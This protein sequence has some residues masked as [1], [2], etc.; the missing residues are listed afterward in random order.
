VFRQAFRRCPNPLEPVALQ[1]NG[2]IPVESEPF[3][4][5]LAELKETLRDALSVQ[6]LESENDLTALGSGAPPGQKKASC[7]A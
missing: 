1:S 4:I 2:A 3:E 5:P 6:V 7:V